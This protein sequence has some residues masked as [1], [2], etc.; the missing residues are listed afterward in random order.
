MLLFMS[1]P[2][3]LHSR[4]ILSAHVADPNISGTEHSAQPSDGDI[5]VQI[6]N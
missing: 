2:K 5:L 6:M 3:S 4:N 1:Y